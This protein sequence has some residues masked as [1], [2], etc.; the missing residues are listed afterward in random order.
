[1]FDTKFEPFGIPSG[2]ISFVETSGCQRAVN[3][4]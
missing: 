4:A 2:S 3:G 1:M